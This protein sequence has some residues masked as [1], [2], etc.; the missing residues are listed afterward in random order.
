MSFG[1]V[2]ATYLA[3]PP[4]SQEIGLVIFAEFFSTGIVIFPEGQAN[5][6]TYAA[7]DLDG[8]FLELRHVVT[9]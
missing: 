6:T 8:E 4:Q 2:V 9:V 7:Y 3:C 5:V 1:V